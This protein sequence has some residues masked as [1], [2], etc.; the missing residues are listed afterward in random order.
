MN[1]I[2]QA[3]FHTRKDATDDVKR[4]VAG[5]QVPLSWA[6]RWIRQLATLLAGLLF[7]LTAGRVLASSST[8]GPTQP[9]LFVV[10]ATDTSMVIELR[11]PVPQLGTTSAAGQIFDTV[12]LDTTYQWTEV[13]GRPLL[14]VRNALVGIPD[15]STVRVDVL[16]VEETLLP[17]SYRVYPVPQLVPAIPAEPGQRTVDPANPPATGT[18]FRFA[19]DE[20]FYA[21]DTLYPA[22][23]VEISNKGY[24]RDQL[25]ARLRFFPLRTNPARNQ[26]WYASRIVV[27]LQFDPPPHPL[28][29][30]LT[31][32]AGQ[33]GPDPLVPRP[34]SFDQALS[35]ALLNYQQAQTWRIPRARA[36][37]RLSKPLSKQSQGLSTA[38]PRYRVETEGEGLVEISYTRLAAAG[39]SVDAIDPATFRVLHHGSDIAIEVTGAADGSFD[40][41]DRIRFYAEQVNSLY[42]SRNVYWL[43]FGGPPG[44]RIEQRS[45]AP[46]TSSVTALDFATTAHFEES[47][48]YQS[49]LPL[50][51]F[52]ADRW[53]WTFT[54]WRERGAIIS[55]TVTIDVGVPSP[56]PHQVT[57]WPR[58]RGAT[59]RFLVDPDHYA[60]LYI[61]GHLIGEAYWDGYEEFMG[62]FQFDNSLLR[63][64]ANTF[65]LETPGQPGLTEDAVF[66]NWLEIAYRQAFEAV[67]DQLRF[68]L[69]GPGSQTI[70]I[71]G[72]STPAIELYDITD[73]SHVVRLTDFSVTAQGGSYRLRFTDQLPAEDHRYL[74]TTN[75]HRLAP[76]LVAR[77]QPS[78]LHHPAAGADYLI[79]SHADFLPAAQALAAHRATTG[80]T[81]MVIDVQDIYDEFNDGLMSPVAIRDFLAY[82]YQNWPEPA[83]AYVLLLGDGTYDFKNYLGFGTPT[84]IPPMLDAVDPFIGETASDNRYV[85]IV[86]NDTLPD[87]HIGR[88]PANTLSEA[89]TMVNKIIAYETSPPPGDWLY[90]LLF[91]TDN[92]DVAGN[93]PYLSNE[94]ADYLIPPPYQV[95]KVYYG[96]NYTDILSARDAIREALNRGT[97]LANYVGHASIT[98]WA[99][100]ILLGVNDVPNLTNDGRLPVMLPM[101]CYDGYFQSPVFASLAETLVRANG[102]GAVASWSATGQGVATGHDYLHRGFYE[103]IF[104]AGVQR[105]GPATLAGKLKLFSE[106]G[107]FLD[108]IDTFGLI[109]DPGLALNL[110][111]ADLAVEMAVTPEGPVQQGDV[112]TFT[113]SYVNND[114]ATVPN[115]VLTT[116]VPL[117]LL[118]ISVSHSDPT[119]SLRP[120][121]H[122]IWDLGPLGNGQ[123][124]VITITGQVP[125]VLTPLDAP[126]STGSRVLSVWPES[127]LRNNK[128]GPLFVP[129]LESDLSV[130]LEPQT[131]PATPG[132]PVNLRISYHNRGP[133]A[134][135]RPKIWFPLPAWLQNPI[136]SYSGPSPT[137]LPGD[138]LHWQ[139]PTLL[140]GQSGI[141]TVTGK[142]DPG[143]TLAA[144]PLKAVIYI[145]TGWLD[146]HPYNNSSQSLGP[147]VFFSDP[148]EP[149][150]NQMQATPLSLPGLSAGHTHSFNGDVDWF[151][152]TA[153]A[154]HRYRIWVRNLSEGGD[155]V[156]VI[157]TIEGTLL[158][159]NDDYVA[160]SRWSGLDWTATAD[161]VYY[162]AVGAAPGSLPGFRY[163]LSISE[164]QNLLF[165]PRL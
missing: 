29:A 22:R 161:G 119:I 141:I 75:A 165:L 7:V 69:S 103:A 118:N 110:P 38:G 24:M 97:L 78:N 21:Q 94:V 19:I 12:S 67:N 142:L 128:G 145:T 108:L 30:S 126:Y 146:L 122:Y 127:N 41:G 32:N 153:Q 13:V 3:V 86:G 79:I 132:E 85:T 56:I 91:V 90:N 45:V 123:G 101:T 68:S 107:R 73:P 62:S 92:A 55:R 35:A 20:D 112:L 9:G 49:D 109:G 99:A 37:V 43:T 16:T 133:A 93:F 120:G 6:S 47:A 155:T 46:A 130:S 100:E 40:P 76:V 154:G 61:N 149:D 2:C 151:Q 48:Y 98:W 139:L 81:P 104:Q 163:D 58:L 44:L 57:L 8:T 156:L 14:P 87:L 80:F 136:F 159:F 157:K 124:G 113:I 115:A 11:V 18:V 36:R 102:R 17:G 121:T 34:T 50:T 164:L 106:S 82:A 138:G 31:T 42:T 95:N 125:D 66:L 77:D 63:P 52:E 84:Y 60:R 71:A 15:Q 64:G 105:L 137:L 89:W 88:L 158:A 147:A 143:L 144:L 150:D 26:L 54:R 114:I 72:F 39:A 10:E 148:Y 116:A 162:L 111:S 152:F 33:T 27:R 70:E 25:V 160:G 83:P 117:A 134:A 74:A 5:N 59:S 28:S 131:E 65:T 129:V 53:Y 51:G 96:E 135:T 23:V 1:M 4:P 140:P